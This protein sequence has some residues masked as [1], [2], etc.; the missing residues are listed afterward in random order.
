MFDLL[1]EEEDQHSQN[2]F[3]IYL[4][5][6]RLAGATE[7]L[8]EFH[9]AKDCRIGYFG[10][11]TGAASASKAAAILP[12]I[13]ALVSRGD[14]PDLVMDVLRNAEAPSL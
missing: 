7:W 1:T 5:T 13:N 8:E 2:R 6:K 10:T 3:N 4:L 11:S 14:R 9:A 12:H